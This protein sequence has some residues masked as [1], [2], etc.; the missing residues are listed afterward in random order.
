[1]MCGS[2]SERR[3]CP[4]CGLGNVTASLKSSVMSSVKQ[5]FGTDFG[6]HLGS[7]L[8]IIRTH[9]SLFA[10]P[11]LKLMKGQTERL[12]H[13]WG[14]WKCYKKLRERKLVCFS[15]F[16]SLS[17]PKAYLFIVL[18]MFLTAF[19]CAS[20]VDLRRNGSRGFCYGDAGYCTQEL[21]L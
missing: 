11:S 8:G 10:Y 16:K 2:S 17:W 20:N 14:S 4:V 12:A 15:S 13:L 7:V 19:L 18:S 3:K 1:M 9:W 21:A 6:T 5:Y